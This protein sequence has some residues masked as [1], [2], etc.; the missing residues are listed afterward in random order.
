MQPTI[1]PAETMKVKT[2]LCFI[3]F[4]TTHPFTRPSEPTEVKVI[5]HAIKICNVESQVMKL[6]SSSCFGLSRLFV[7]LV[8]PLAQEIIDSIRSLDRKRLKAPTERMGSNNAANK[9]KCNV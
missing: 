6:L 3:Y 9:P 5:W 8:G 7:G 4:L 1:L 2:V